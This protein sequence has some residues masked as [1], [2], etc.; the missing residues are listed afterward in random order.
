MED[1]APRRVMED[2]SKERGHKGRPRPFLH[3]RHRGG[4]MASENGS[5]GEEERKSQGG[6]EGGA[7][8]HGP[9][10]PAAAASPASLAHAAALGLH[11]GHGVV[12]HAALHARPHAGH[13]PRHSLGRA[14]V[15]ASTRGGEIEGG[16]IE[17]VSDRHLN[18]AE[19]YHS[20]PRGHQQQVTLL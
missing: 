9:A 1:T 8:L 20:V 18:Q 17:G 16:V 4:G 19:R 3:R 14:G 7:D 5:Q 2:I 15:P 13:H 10:A 12:G 11:H 6:E